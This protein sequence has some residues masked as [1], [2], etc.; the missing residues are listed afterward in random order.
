MSSPSFMSPESKPGHRPKLE[1]LEQ[2]FMFFTW[3]RLGFTQSYAGF[4]FNLPIS[5]VCR[6]TITWSNYMYLKLE[7][8]PIW[9]TREQ[10]DKT[11]PKCFKETYPLTRVILDCTEL[12]CQRPS[13]L[14]IQSSLFSF[15]KHHV[16]Y[17]GLVGISPSG[18][19]T[20]ASQLFDDSISDVEIVRRSGI[21]QKELW[22]S[23]DSVMADRGFTIA[24]ELRNIGVSL[25]IPSLL[26]GR[27]QLTEEE[28]TESQTI[29]AVRIHVER[30]IQRIKIFR[31]IRN[32]MTR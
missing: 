5:T 6:Y 23:G 8:I 9:P 24:E 7:S 21:L 11:M 26:S 3:L 14:T 31:Q 20:F 18:A 17:K 25:N 19:I 4:L 16:A 1:E 2:L 30:A 15:Y 12:F 10:T 22:K 28:V 29:A 27:N 13:S 32:E